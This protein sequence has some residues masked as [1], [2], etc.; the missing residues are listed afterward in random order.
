MAGPF[1]SAIDPPADGY[2]AA[3]AFLAALKACPA[4]AGFDN[5]QRLAT[6]MQLTLMA[7]EAVDQAALEDALA[8]LGATAGWALADFSSE[9]Q[10]RAMQGLV[11]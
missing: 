9:V 5:S 1:P 11:H 10:Q 8:A 4:L 6:A 2:A 3:Q 7:A